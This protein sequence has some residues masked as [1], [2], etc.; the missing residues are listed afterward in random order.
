MKVVQKI[1]CLT[2]LA[3]LMGIPLGSLAVVKEAVAHAQELALL[4]QIEEKIIGTSIELEALKDA[5]KGE[6]TKTKKL[7]NQLQK[8]EGTI[9]LKTYLKNRVE[10]LERDM[11]QTKKSIA[12]L[13]E[14]K[15]LKDTQKKEIAKNLTTRIELITGELETIKGLDDI[16]SAES[17]LR[18]HLKQLE[19]VGRI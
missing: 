17:Y 9:E 12:K 6:Q 18:D 7:L 13:Q 8:G 1:V 11:E 14:S 3:V 15:D 10:S 4:A 5:V 2:I 16:P 19:S